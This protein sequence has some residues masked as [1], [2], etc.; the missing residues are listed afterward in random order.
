[1]EKE[2]KNKNMIIGLSLA[3][4]F[5]FTIVAYLT[6]IEKVKYNLNALDWFIVGGI[7]SLAPSFYHHYNLRRIDLIEE[8]LSDF[9]RDIAESKRFG[10]TLADSI[11]KTAKGNYG[12]LTPEIKKMAT[13]IE[14][15]VSATEA[16][17]LFGERVNTPLVN[18]AVAIA[19]KAS[20]AGGDIADVLTISS[21]NTKDIQLLREERKMKMSSYIAVIYTAFFVFLAVVII[22]NF[23]FLPSMTKANQPQATTSEVKTSAENKG[24][25]EKKT[26]EVKTLYLYAAIIQGFG[27]GILAGVIENGRMLTGLRHSFIMS[28]A[29]FVIIRFAVL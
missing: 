23:V 2:L 18:R 29:A 7:L 15:G 12:A 10:M 8:R 27:N 26:A 9:L 3:I 20:K 6:Y 14:W 11:R 28:L 24:T 21:S 13:Q 19:I 16:L 25:I 17:R 1:M 22:L 4:F 5:S